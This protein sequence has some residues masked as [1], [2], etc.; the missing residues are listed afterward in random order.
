MKEAKNNEIDLMLRS[1]ARRVQ[2][3]SAG[4]S[5]E[6]EPAVGQGQHLDADELNSYAENA[7]PAF[8]RARYTEHLAD[9]STC[10]KIAAQLSLASGATLRPFS[11]QERKPWSLSGFLSAVFSASVLRYTVPALSLI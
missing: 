10:R 9:C 11:A 4:H 3:T 5:L 8:A 6:D 7:L 1:L 2:S